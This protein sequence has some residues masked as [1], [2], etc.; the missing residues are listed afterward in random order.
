MSANESSFT[1]QRD[2]DPGFSA[3]TTM[4]IGPS[5]PNT[6]YGTTISF[7][8]TTA[9]SG[10]SY[11]YRVQAV[12][13]NFKPPLTQTWS[14]TPAL[15]SAWSNTAPALVACQ[16]LVSSSNP[17]AGGTVTV[18]TTVSIAKECLLGRSMHG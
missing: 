11:Y 15:L 9:G 16:S 2:V 10:T 14:A 7:T 12:D 13:D 3:P 6:S 1:L 5:V 18:N 17:A 8:D 4:Q